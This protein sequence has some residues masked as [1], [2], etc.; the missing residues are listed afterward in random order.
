[1]RIDYNEAAEIL[2]SCDNVL[3]LAHGNPDGDTVGSTYGLCRSLRLAGKKANVSCSDEIPSRY[4]Y[5]SEGWYAPLEFE[6]QIVIACDV[7]SSNLLGE[8]NEQLWGDKIDLCIDHHYSN[9]EYAKK[10]LLG[11]NA[12]CCEVIYELLKKADLPID[13]TAAVCLYTGIATDTGCFKFENV[14]KTT[15]LIAA[16]LYEYDIPFARINRKLFDIKSHAKIMIEQRVLSG[17]ELFFDG[18]CAVAS[19]TLEMA[20]K[21]GFDPGEFEGLATLPMQI[22]GVDVGI[23][24]R[25]KEPDNFKISVRTSENANA[26][27]ICA[28]LGGGGHIRAGGCKINGSLAEAKEKMLKAAAEALGHVGEN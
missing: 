28:K 11:S 8:K 1:M 22:E 18:K 25:E 26:S 17:M 16:E 3:I 9:T 14:T 15:H 5:M 19:V 12:A 27:E 21:E 23:T 7:A 2:R 10:L 4:D 24:L 13:D 6:P 20:E